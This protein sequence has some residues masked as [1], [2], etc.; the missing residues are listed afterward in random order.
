MN[1]FKQWISILMLLL[2]GNLYAEIYK[3]PGY[4]YGSSLEG[5]AFSFDIGYKS[6]NEDYYLTLNPTL[7]LPFFGL[8]IGLQIPLEVLI[9]D[10]EP[11]SAQKTPSLR[12]GMYESQEDYFRIFRYITYGT[13]L[14]FDPDDSFNWSLHY[15]I[16]NDG[17]IGHRTI[18]NRYVSSY[19]PTVWSP[20]LMADIN[21]N[22]GG[23]EV[24]ANNVLRKEVRGYRIFIR[25]VGIFNSISNLSYNDD[26]N[27]QEIVHST[28]ENQNPMLN[29]NYLFQT[30]VPNMGKG[31][32]LKHHLLKPLKEDLKEEKIEFKEVYDPNTGE[33]KI[34]PVPKEEIPLIEQE[35]KVQEAEQQVQPK[36][37]KE[38][39]KKIK[40]EHGFWNRWAIGFT[41]ITDYGA[42]LSLELDGSSNLVID[43]ETRL[44][45]ADKVENLT[46]TGM[47]MELRLSPFR[48]LDITPYIDI[49][50]IKNLSKSK[51]THIGINIEMN[52]SKLFKFTLRPEYREI[53]SNYIAEYFDSTYAIERTKY[54]QGNSTS[55]TPKLAYL[56]SLPTD[57][58]I[59]KGY[60]IN[61]LMEFI[62]LL[63]IEI[64][65]TDY[66]GPNNSEIFTGFYIPNLGGFFVNGYYIKKYFD[67]F[68]D[69]FKT[70]SENSLLAAEAGLSFFGGFYI[71]YMIQRTWIYNSETGEY[72]P[73]DES[74]IGFG[75]GSNF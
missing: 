73:K 27:T 74:S 10:K 48:W 68:S 34:V 57:G 42:P 12:K 41:S 61:A 59:Y 37:E 46:I 5:N 25:P 62:S 24:F 13:H 43:P 45:R 26:I 15:G 36:S 56:K 52:L 72:Q 71:K 70:K 58:A 50:K 44:P 11:L 75:Y 7:E 64:S 22:W 29:R 30:I 66:K 3:P 14:Y 40:R 38:V 21:N 63:V 20:G 51:G 9:Y 55:V 65:Y 19:D 23:V 8:R 67:K 6:L 47:D 18:V 39:P 2:G 54:L 33:V 49:N 17:Y 69:A 32:A 16:M 53:T 35:K 60:F 28:I 4:G 1:R 31:G